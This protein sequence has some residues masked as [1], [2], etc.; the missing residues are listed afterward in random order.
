[1]LGHVIQVVSR[2]VRE[3]VVLVVDQVVAGDEVEAPGAQLRG[4][5]E[6]GGEQEAWGREGG[7]GG[8]RGGGG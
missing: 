7:G 4:I 2:D 1:M 5:V 8:G 6:L 3:A